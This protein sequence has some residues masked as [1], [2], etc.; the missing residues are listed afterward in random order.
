MKRRV[1]RR[2]SHHRKKTS[3]P[4]GT[5]IGAAVAVLFLL[6]VLILKRQGPPSIAAVPSL[7]QSRSVQPMASKP[8]PAAKPAQPSETPQPTAPAVLKRPVFV[9]APDPRCHKLGR[10]NASFYRCGETLVLLKDGAEFPEDLKSA[11]WRTTIVELKN[12]GLIGGALTTEKGD[13]T[14]ATTPNDARIAE[15]T[16]LSDIGAFDVWSAVTGNPDLTVAILDSGIDLTHPDLEANLWINEGEVP[17]NGTDDDGNGYIDDANG[18][19]FNAATADNQDDKGH[20]THGAGVIGAVGNNGIGGAGINW[21]VNLLPLKITDADGK[22]SLAAAVE[23]INYAIE[24]HARV[25]NASW[26]MTLSTPDKVNLLQTAI[27][28]A[29][30]AGIVFVA[31]AGN[32]AGQDIDATP[33]Y[34]ASLDVPGVVTVAA[35][36]ADHVLAS[37]SNIGANSVDLAAPGTGILSTALGG[38][39]SSSAGTSVATTVVSGA[40]ALML[41]QKPSLSPAEVRNIL[42]ETAT[43]SAS[44]SGKT[45]SGG[46]LNLKGAL[47]SLGATFAASAASDEPKS[48]V[49]A[50]APKSSSSGSSGGGC[51]LTPL[52]N[53]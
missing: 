29:V 33:L 32:N 18:Y 49:A 12:R 17:G 14:L 11:P 52:I 4:L 16:Y 5:A 20:G 26:V 8:A 9:A 48:D 34:P 15:Q 36:D 35:V 39:F 31:A 6:T 30:S 1:V 40:A 37:F 50:A 46:T 42:M 28:D 7:P 21:N 19:N 22:A 2:H 24:N 3:F 53:Y 45:V 27:Q 23:A 41:A 43:P 51:A 25:I 13:I 10:L 44:L 47:A 38:D